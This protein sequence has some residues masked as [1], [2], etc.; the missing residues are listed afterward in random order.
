VA[1]APQPSRIDHRP[2][3]RNLQR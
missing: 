3:R 2:L 1:Y